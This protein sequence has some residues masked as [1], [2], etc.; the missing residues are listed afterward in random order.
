MPFED[1]VVDRWAVDTQTSGTGDATAT[2][3]ATA[4][5][6]HVIMAAGGGGSTAGSV[7]VRKGTTVIDQFRFAANTSEYRPYPPGTLVGDDNQLVEVTAD[8]T[9][10][11]DSAEAF[12]AGYTIQ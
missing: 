11:T 10:G 9:A 1:K 3:A 8:V 12:I 5:K 2:K 4:D 6:K 7:I